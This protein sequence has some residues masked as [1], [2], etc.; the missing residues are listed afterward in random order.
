MTVAQAN[1]KNRFKGIARQSGSAILY[2]PENRPVATVHGNQSAGAQILSLNAGI[3]ISANRVFIIVGRVEG[4]VPELNPSNVLVTSAENVNA[5][6]GNTGANSG[7]DDDVTSMEIFRAVQ[8]AG[9][10]DFWDDPAEDLYPTKD[11]TPK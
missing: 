6:T 9:A 8:T 1:V 11:G 3:A 7:Y 4:M 2:P 10:F 5:K